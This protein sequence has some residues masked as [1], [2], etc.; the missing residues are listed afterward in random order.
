MSQ[1]TIT[2][3]PA[4]AEAR[5]SR[6]NLLRLAGAAAV[7][8][9]GASLLATGSASAA[10][11]AMQYGGTNE[12]GNSATV[13]NS[14]AA[15]TLIVGNGNAGS[16]IVGQSTASGTGVLGQMSQPTASAYGVQGSINGSLGYGVVA[17]GG[18]AQLRLAPMMGVGP[19]NIVATHQ[20]GEIAYDMST[21]ALWVCVDAG[22]PGTW[23]KLGG[24]ATAG[25]FHAISPSR[26]WDSRKAAAP[27]ST[28]QNVTRSVANKL[29]IFGAVDIPNIVPAKATAIAFTLTVTKTVGGSGY[30]SVNEG[31][32]TEI[33]ASTINWF[34][35]NQTHAN[36]SI[37]K[38]NDQ[39]QVNV[40]C[41]GAAGAKT[42]YIIDVTGY[43]L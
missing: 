41:G 29:D 40:H 9:A 25:A 43:Y 23:R 28:G 13:L 6:R 10:T 1:T 33:S 38:V 16:A 19:S 17:S 8:G 39:R 42:D 15:S 20:I 4:A 12:A 37:V 34:G 2:T 14:T 7:A 31:G 30:L 11:G 21:N 27:I 35:D 5:S 3:E 32:N 36:S 24:L 22:S 18:Q 26:V